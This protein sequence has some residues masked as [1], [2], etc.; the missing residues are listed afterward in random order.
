MPR[1]TESHSSTGRDPQAVRPSSRARSL[2]ISRYQACQAEPFDITAIIRFLQPKVGVFRRVLT[3]LCQAA[4]PQWSSLCHTL[5]SLPNQ[6]CLIRSPLPSSCDVCHAAGRGGGISS[7]CTAW[8][9]LADIKEG[10]GAVKASPRSLSA[11]QL[12]GWRRQHSARHRPKHSH[13]PLL[14]STAFQRSSSLR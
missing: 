7:L 9:G 14:H 1:A 8:N 6:P 5:P 4:T 12:R 3:S 11:Q 2:L 13:H 10:K